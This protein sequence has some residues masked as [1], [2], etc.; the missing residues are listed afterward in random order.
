MYSPCQHHNVA[1]DEDM[2][3][4][5]RLGTGS[6]HN[7]GAVDVHRKGVEQGEK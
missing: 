6:E 4:T 5:L 1:Y 3:V 2:R 7:D